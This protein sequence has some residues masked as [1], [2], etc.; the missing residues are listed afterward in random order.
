MGERAFSDTATDDDLKRMAQIAKEAV[1]AGA[2]GFSTSRTKN[3]QT[4]DHKPVA[5]RIADWNEVRAIVN[6]PRPFLRAAQ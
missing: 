2:M 6:A 1:Q 3:H 4:S 5:S